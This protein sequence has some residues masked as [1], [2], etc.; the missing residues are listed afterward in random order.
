MNPLIRILRE[1]LQDS[2]DIFFSLPVLGSN[3]MMPKGKP[4]PYLFVDF[5]DE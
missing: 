2:W 5:F 1:T 4:R 3:H